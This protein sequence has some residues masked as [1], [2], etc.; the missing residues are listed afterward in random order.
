MVQFDIL[1]KTIIIYILLVLI[2]YFVKPQILYDV[3]KQE[4][5]KICII[6]D[7]YC[8]SI[9]SLACMSSFL[10]YIG[11]I[12]MSIDDVKVSHNYRLVQ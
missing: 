3:E 10:I 2:I 1:T 6:Q 11:I 4:F 5:K 7:Q 12:Y 9:Y 8:I